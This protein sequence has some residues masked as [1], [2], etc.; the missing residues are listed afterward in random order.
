MRVLPSVTV[1]GGSITSAFS[2]FTLVKSS[3]ETR[4]SGDMNTVISTMK[5]VHPE[6]INFFQ[7]VFVRVCLLT[8]M[9]IVRSKRRAYVAMK[10]C[11]NTKRM[12]SWR[13]VQKYV[14]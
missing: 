3:S 2:L 14:T 1:S 10:N 9:K 7:F 11:F 6:A 12:N 5:A 13:C 8:S 4:G